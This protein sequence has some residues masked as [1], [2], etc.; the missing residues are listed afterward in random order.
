MKKILNIKALAVALMLLA[1]ACSKDYLETSPTNQVA[2]SDAFSTTKNAFAAVNGIHRILYS[3]IYGSQ[4]QG[5]QSGNMMYMDIMGEDVVMNTIANAGF[6]SEY[7]W[8]SHRNS[9]SIL[10]EY[11]YSFYYMIIG[12]ANM[13]IANI[14][15]AEGPQADKNAIKG[16]ALVYRAWAYFQMIQLFGERYIA[17][18]PNSELGVPLVL[19]PTVEKT[20]RSTVAQVY[21]QINT[22]IDAAIVSLTGYNRGNT[23]KSQLNINVAKGIKARIALTQQNWADAAKFAQEARQG[24]T[25]MTNAQYQAGFND[26]GNPEW[27]WASRITADQTNFFY[28]YFAYI[29]SNYNSTAIRTSPRSIFSVLYD[30]ITTTDVRKKLWDPTG[31]NTAFPIPL[32]GSRFRYM[33]NK[34]RVADPGLSIGD[35]P[36]MR[37][38]EMYLIEAEALARSGNNTGAVTA[39]LP[40]AVNRDPSYT[41]STK[42]GAALIDEIMTQ[43]RI[44]LWGEGFRFYDLK[45]TNSALNRNGG[46]HIASVA[47]SVLEVPANDIRWQFLIPQE[48][49]NIGNG[50]VVQNPQ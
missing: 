18:S 44:E 38:A 4:P 25:L 45:R 36:Y 41:L 46:N 50:V 49:I 11:S 6:R 23:D 37:V 26:Y 8:L 3:Q 48:E 31:A 24:F 32:N 43:R 34:F 29:S 30:R 42:T 40:L 39:L 28:S 19:A 33:H 9:N 5:G 14:D 35:V 1:S 16:Q 12:N 2:T 47:N 17:G 13:I 20:P 7:Q 15:N 22:D 27:M 21:A 10:S